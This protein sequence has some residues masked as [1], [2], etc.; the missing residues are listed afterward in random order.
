MLAFTMC[1]AGCAIRLHSWAR[2]LKNVAPQ[3]QN[4]ICKTRAQY[5]KHNNAFELFKEIAP[6]QFCLERKFS[7][8][9]FIAI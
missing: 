1:P 4:A 9:S 7:L 2:N 3:K 6:Q 5:A 8:K